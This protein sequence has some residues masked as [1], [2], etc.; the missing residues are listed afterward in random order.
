MTTIKVEV[1]T[2]LWME[3]KNIVTR[4]ISLEKSVVALIEKAIAEKKSQVPKKEE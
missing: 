4:N 3:Y 2:E 1:P